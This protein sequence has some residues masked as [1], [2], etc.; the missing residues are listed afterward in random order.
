M[1]QVDELT[2]IA[3]KKIDLAKALLRASEKGEKPSAKAK[4]K[5]KAKSGAGN[6]SGS[7]Q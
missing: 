2:K 3:K 5:A 1:R 4:A 6:N 7:E